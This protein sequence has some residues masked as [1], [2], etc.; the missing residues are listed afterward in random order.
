MGTD[1]GE[2]GAVHI[3]IG[4]NYGGLEARAWTV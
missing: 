3:L 2:D 1:Y 4:D